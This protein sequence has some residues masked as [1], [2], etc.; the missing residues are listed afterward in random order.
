M[1]LVAEAPHSVRP[2]AGRGYGASPAPSPS[3]MLAR[4]YFARLSSR[5]THQ[6][7]RR[8]TGR[9]VPRQRQQ[10]AANLPASDT[11]SLVPRSRGTEA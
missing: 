1:M 8:F 2:R 9:A 11:H 10:A 5:T 7:A 4:Q 3:L 6:L